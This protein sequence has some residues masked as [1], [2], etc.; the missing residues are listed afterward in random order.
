MKRKL[1]AEDDAEA[2]DGAATISPSSDFML[3]GCSECHMRILLP[4]VEDF[5]FGLFL[6]FMYQ[7]GYDLEIDN[8]L[9]VISVG[10]MNAQ[11]ERGRA[12]E[13]HV[14]PCKP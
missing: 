8:R 13:Q 6:R 14:G 7:G 3:P 9:R 4:D 10:M 5:I 11:E 2:N 12:S 1:N